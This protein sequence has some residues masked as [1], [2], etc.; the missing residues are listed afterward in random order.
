MTETDAGGLNAYLTPDDVGRQIQHAHGG[1]HPC[2]KKV[3]LESCYNGRN[4]KKP[5]WT[6][7]FGLAPADVEAPRGLTNGI[8][9][10]WAYFFQRDYGVRPDAACAPQTSGIAPVTG[11]SL[12]Q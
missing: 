6:M 10:Y 3:I 11:S 5:R 8:G 12:T 4:R 9:R 7:A 1:A 2:L